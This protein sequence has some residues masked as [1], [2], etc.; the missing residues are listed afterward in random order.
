MDSRLLAGKLVGDG[1]YHCDQTSLRIENGMLSGKIQS[2]RE[3]PHNG[4]VYNLEVE[5][6]HSYVANGTTVHNCAMSLAIANL[7]L[8][9]AVGGTPFYIDLGKH[10][11]HK[12]LVAT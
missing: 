12:T 1:A 10:P 3:V 2:V 11:I 6:D 7:L 4:M 8:R 5:D 9:K